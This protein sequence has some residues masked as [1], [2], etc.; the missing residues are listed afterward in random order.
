MMLQEPGSLRVHC[1]IIWGR[2]TGARKFAAGMARPLG[3]SQL[4]PKSP[5]GA[6]QELMS[7]LALRGAGAAVHLTP[8]AG[9]ETLPGLHW[10]LLG[11]A[12]ATAGALGTHEETAFCMKR[13][14][15]QGGQGDEP[16]EGG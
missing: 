10:R 7:Q 9:T 12:A 15:R 1:R 2:S 13:V 5:L 3:A 4:E 16:S 8:D 14:T 6:C 11:L